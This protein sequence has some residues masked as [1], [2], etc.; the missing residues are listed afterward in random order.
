LWKL[1]EGFQKQLGFASF[2]LSIFS[3]FH[4]VSFPAVALMKSAVEEV[5][6]PL[7]GNI[8]AYE[9]EAF[10]QD[11]GLVTFAANDDFP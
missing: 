7:A 3:G 4:Q 11:N 2:Q 10:C 8:E 9:P 6:A 5:I 1:L